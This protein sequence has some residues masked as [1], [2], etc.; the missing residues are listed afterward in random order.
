MAITLVTAIRLLIPFTILR[1]PFWGALAA[2]AADAAD[3][4]I[5]EALGAEFGSAAR[6]QTFDKLFDLYYLAF[7]FYASRAWQELLTRRT[8]TILFAWRIAGTIV[9][10]LTHV[11]QVIFFAPNIFENFYLLVA[12]ARQF[13]PRFRLDSSPKLV[14]FLLIAGIPKIIQEYIMHFLEFSTWAFIKHTVLRWR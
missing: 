8:A 9:F 13:V 7:E 12:G 14:L 1:W 6:Y 5:V 3:I 11:R 2:I 10:E 4:V